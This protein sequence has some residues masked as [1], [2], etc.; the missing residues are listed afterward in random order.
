MHSARHGMEWNI[1][2]RARIGRQAERN[3]TSSAALQNNL[4]VARIVT[5]VVR[6]QMESQSPSLGSSRTSSGA[7]IGPALPAIHVH[8]QLAMG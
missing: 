8:G 1:S 6:A 2:I 3:V 4:A 5:A 7:L